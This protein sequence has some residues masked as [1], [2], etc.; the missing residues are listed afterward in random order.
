MGEV[1]EDS[2]E[3]TTLEGIPV[4][5]AFSRSAVSNWTVAIGIPTRS[6]T[7]DL[8]QQHWW[9]VLGLVV[10][11]LCTL[12]LAWSIGRRISRSIHGLSG[13]ALALGYGGAVTVP[14]LHLR[15]ADEVGRA[16]VKASG[17]LQE[18]Q[19]R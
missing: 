1:A 2:L 5:T 14:P 11:L 10:L 19:H 15:E 12:F 16:L 9:L 4:L 7:G 6:L 8:W 3:T 13:P 17:M 18:A